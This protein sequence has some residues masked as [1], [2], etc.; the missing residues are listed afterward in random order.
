MLDDNRDRLCGFCA[1]AMVVALLLAG[2]VSSAATGRWTVQQAERWYAA[3]PWLVGCNYTPRTAVNQLE[4]WQA[5]TFD[6]NT[7]DQE[8]T[9]AEGIG[10]NVVR[11]YLHYIPFKQDAEGFYNRIEKFLGI[12]RKHGIRVMFV[13]LDDC[14]DPNPTPG[15][16]KPPRPGVHNSRW[17]QCPGAKILSDPRR[18]AE[19]KPYIQ[20]VIRRFRDDKRVLCWDI[21][22]EPGA[23]AGTRY[24]T[25]DVKNKAK[26]SAMLL[27]EAFDWARQVSPS[28]PLTA[29]LWSGG[30]SDPNK[31][32][33]ISRLCIERSDIMTF[34]CYASPRVFRGRA[35]SVL[36]YHRPVICTEY[37]NRYS[38]CTFQAVL[39][40]MKAKRIGAINWGLVAGRIQT[41][42]PWSSWKHPLPA[43]P[44]VWPHDLLRP[45]GRPFDPAEV[46][47]IR[48]LTGRG[49]ATRSP[50]R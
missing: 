13:L 15:P 11:V 35:E 39:P 40:Y 46:E 2:A 28:Q 23:Y 9:W 21:Y 34:H 25:A 22:N 33:P 10:F 8:L 4:F 30:W 19:L 6:A 41:Q 49:N 42:Y 16:Q 24:P 14:W 7:I 32:S 38:G 44:K 48:R 29:G 31:L 37:L 45:N 18:H 27:A 26:F 3:R 36:K 12:C 17:V 5:A 43:E 1:A 50:A 47:L 20:G